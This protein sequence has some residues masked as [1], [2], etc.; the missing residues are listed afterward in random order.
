MLPKHILLLIVNLLKKHLKEDGQS[1]DIYPIIR[2]TISRG[3]P[4]IFI[5]HRNGNESNYYCGINNPDRLV[6]RM[7]KRKPNK[8]NP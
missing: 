8:K 7:I 6:N 3:N 4:Q 2:I 5:K 1:L